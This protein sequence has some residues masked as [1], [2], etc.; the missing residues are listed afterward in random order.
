MTISYDSIYAVVCRIPEGSVATYGQIARLL[1]MSGHA[2]RVG[3]ALAALR[4]PT[5]VPWH[6]VI[7]ARGEI[8]RRADPGYEDYQR[9]LLES[10]GIEFDAHGRIALSKFQWNPSA[11]TVVEGSLP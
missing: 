6:R 10:E 11:A 9:I 1:G 2:R 8:S 5:T 3:Y 7:N 4:E